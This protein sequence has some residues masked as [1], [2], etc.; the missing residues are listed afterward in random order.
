MYV[1]NMFG[2]NGSEP[3]FVL[4]ADIDTSGSTPVIWKKILTP[5]MMEVNYKLAGNAVD[6]T[7]NGSITPANAATEYY[8]GWVETPWSKF[9]DYPMVATYWQYC[10]VQTSAGNEPMTGYILVLSR[11]HYLN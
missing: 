2:V 11:G 8:T 4:L 6:V 3:D 10:Q 5:D 1:N 7:G 9:S